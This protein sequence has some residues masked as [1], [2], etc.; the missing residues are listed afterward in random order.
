MRYRIAEGFQ[1]LVDFFQLGGAFLELA[2]ALLKLCGALDHPGFK[3][4]ID[5][6]Q[7]VFRPPRRRDATGNQ[8]V[9]QRQGREQNQRKRRNAV[10]QPRFGGSLELLVADQ[11]LLCQGADAVDTVVDLEGLPAA[12]ILHHQ[13]LR[14]LESPRLVCGD[15]LPESPHA[16]LDVQLQFK[17]PGGLLGIVVN[18]LQEALQFGADIREHPAVGLQIAGVAGDQV[19]AVAGFGTGDGGTHTFQPAQDVLALGD[20]TGCCLEHPRLVEGEQ[21]DHREGD[22]GKRKSGQR[23][24]LGFAAVAQF[25]APAC[26]LVWRRVQVRHQ[27]RS[28]GDGGI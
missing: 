18:Q 14:C 9:N 15:D 28:G 8:G 17:C 7:Q 10:A 21:G 2:A 20:F 11:M 12:G 1:L 16:G 23:Q 5:A 22:N 19:A 27:I 24:V 25:V 4:D 3:G 26:S 6:V 13:F